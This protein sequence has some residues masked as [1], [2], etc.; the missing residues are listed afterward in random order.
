MGGVTMTAPKSTPGRPPHP[1]ERRVRKSIFV[2]PSV[3]AALEEL[4]RQDDRTVS[5][6]AEKAAL[7]YIERQAR[8]G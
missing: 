5:Y 1:G 6:M 4:A 2:R 3:W 8:K 7:E